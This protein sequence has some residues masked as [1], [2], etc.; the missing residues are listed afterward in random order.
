MHRAW[1]LFAVL[2]LL[3]SPAAV[4]KADL[5]DSHHHGYRHVDGDTAGHHHGDADDHHESS[6]SPCHHHETE[7]CTGH[8]HELAVSSVISIVEPGAAELFTVPSASPSDDPSI[9]TIFH[10]PIA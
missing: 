4:E 6:D 3:G 7:I 2:G 5:S 10:I 1:V 9:R 8:A